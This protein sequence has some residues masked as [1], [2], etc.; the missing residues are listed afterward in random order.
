MCNAPVPRLSHLALSPLRSRHSTCLAPPLDNTPPAL[1]RSR[2]PAPHLLHP[3]PCSSH[4]CAA[5]PVPR[6]SSRT[7]QP[8]ASRLLSRTHICPQN[9][10]MAR[11]TFFVTFC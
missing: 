8:V 5:P 4:S 6:A 11:F 9:L 1:P 2:L 3:A 10:P 7:G